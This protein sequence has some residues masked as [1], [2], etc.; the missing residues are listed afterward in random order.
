MQFAPAMSPLMRLWC[1]MHL[2]GR[3]TAQCYC[4]HCRLS[5]QVMAWRARVMDS[6][7]TS[8]ADVVL[9]IRIMRQ[10]RL[11]EVCAEEIC[12]EEISAR[13]CKTTLYSFKMR[14]PGDSPAAAHIVSLPKLL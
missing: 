3:R 14:R 12:M 5:R 8:A 4:C 2:V 11:P 7:S 6:T 13:S 1:N 10:F 9:P